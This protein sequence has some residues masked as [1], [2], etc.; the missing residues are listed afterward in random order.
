MGATTATKA[1]DYIYTYMDTYINGG[2]YGPKEWKSWLD[3][4][5]IN[6]LP[7]KYL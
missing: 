2:I 6:R 5:T 3:D 4:I 7:M 1:M